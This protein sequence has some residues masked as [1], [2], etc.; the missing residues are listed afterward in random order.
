V[1][2][3]VYHTSMYLENKFSIANFILG[4]KPRITRHPCD[5]VFLRTSPLQLICEAEG[6]TSYKWEKEDG[7]I[8]QHAGGVESNTLVFTT[9]R[10]LDVGNYRCVVTGDGESVYSNYAKVTIGKLSIMYQN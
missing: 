2:H 4:T 1:L 9:L 8:P 10:Q 5:A 6:A 7:N 3:H